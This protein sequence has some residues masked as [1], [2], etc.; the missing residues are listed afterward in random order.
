MG[1]SVAR[2]GGGG[3]ADATRARILDAALETLKREGIVGTSARAIG[4]TGGFAPALLFYH[5]GSVNDLL[6]AAVEEL[7]R[8]RV[9]RYAQRLEGVT[10][11]AELAEVARDLHREDMEEGHVRV[12]V[13]M[14]AATG[15]D[16]ELAARL[17]A[18]F[19]PWIALVRDTLERAAGSGLG[20]LVPAEDGAYA[21]TALFLGLELLTHLGGD[22]ARDERLFDAFDR[23]ASLLGPLLGLVSGRR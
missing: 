13:Q 18:I 8:Q 5:Y 11:L 3:T 1:A 12:L 14:L 7:S 9:A 10:T 23:I 2:R 21:L 20:A 16:P 4:Q 6:V 19:E 17:M 22:T 15:S